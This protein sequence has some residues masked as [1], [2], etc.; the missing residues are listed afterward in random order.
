MNMDTPP[1]AEP[2]RDACGDR[3]PA[4]CFMQ[5][6]SLADLLELLGSPAD[7]RGRIPDSIP[8][9]LWRVPQHAALVHEGSR[10]RSIYVVRHGFF[11]R[12]KT[13]ED[14]YEQV[15]SFMQAGEILCFEALHNGVQPASLVALET[16]SVYV[17]PV[18]ELP[19]LHLRCPQLAEALQRALS[20]QLL[21]ATESVEMMAAVSSEVRVARFLMWWSSRMASMGQSP[22]RLRLRM[23]RRDIASLLGVAHETVSRSLTSLSDEGLLKVSNRDVEILDMQRLHA[24]ARCTRSPASCDRERRDARPVNPG[25]VQHSADAVM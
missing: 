12:S 23:C 6:G 5:R 11:K 8:L 24:R 17:L 7:D 20:R 10:G 3:S 13:L 22:R 9:T 19:S 16:S 2:G 4:A 14:G 25:A 21:H 1:F 15:L 18:A